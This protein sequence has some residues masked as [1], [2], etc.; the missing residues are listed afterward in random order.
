MGDTVNSFLMGIDNRR[1]AVLV[2]THFCVSTYYVVGKCLKE[3]VAG[4]FRGVVDYGLREKFLV[5]GKI[6]LV[7]MF[8]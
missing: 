8:L 7:V 6:L 5:K 1:F 4:Y 3:L 2:G